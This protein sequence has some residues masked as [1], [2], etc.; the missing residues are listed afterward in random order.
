MATAAQPTLGEDDASSDLD[1]TRE[2]MSV[3]VDLAAMGPQETLALYVAS[4][5]ARI[6]RALGATRGFAVLGVK[7]PCPPKDDPLF[8]WRVDLCYDVGPKSHEQ[9]LVVAQDVREETYVHDPL[10]RDTCTAAGRHRVAHVPDP[11]RLAAHRDTVEAKYW[12]MFSLRDRLKAIY[13]LS[14]TVELHLSFD[15]SSEAEPYGHREARLLELVTPGIAPWVQRFALMLGRLDGL[16]VLSPRER[17]VAYGLLGR[18][19][20]KNLA[21]NLS[22]SEARARELIRSVYKKLRVSG[23]MELANKWASSAV[24]PPAPLGSTMAVGR[25]R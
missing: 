6:G 8:G 4:G 12:T 2:A 9:M 1:L 18:S 20:V 22:M 7:M 15:R 11:R 10:I 14:P 21:A 24:T 25:G 13:A 17:E 5:H 19:D 23:R 3:C 16:A